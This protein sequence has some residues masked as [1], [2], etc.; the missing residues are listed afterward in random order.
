MQQ[1]EASER[2]PTPGTQL[3][4]EWPLLLGPVLGALLVCTLGPQYLGDFAGAISVSGG[5]IGGLFL[6]VGLSLHQR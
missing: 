6:G 1:M 2:P 3:L 5:S 4:L